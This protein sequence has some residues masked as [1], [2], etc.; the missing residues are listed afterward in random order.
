MVASSVTFSRTTRNLPSNPRE[1]VGFSVRILYDLLSGEQ[2]Q[3][4]GGI[5]IEH[6]LA[7]QASNKTSS[8]CEQATPS[9]HE[10]SLSSGLANAVTWCGRQSVHIGHWG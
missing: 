9:T 2:R 7:A 4:K 5:T 10:C 8:T 3:V 1:P 6:L